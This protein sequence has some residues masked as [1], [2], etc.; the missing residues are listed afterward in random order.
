VRHPSPVDLGRSARRSF[1]ASAVLVVIAL[2]LAP[3][4]GE[5]FGAAFYPTQSVGNR[6]TDVGAIQLLLRHRGLTT[7]FDRNFGAQTVA[8]VKAFQSRAALTVNGIVGPATWAKLVVPLATGATGAAVKA[9]Q[10]ELNQKRSAGL[11]LDGTYGT[12]TRAAVAA[13]QR[14][15][16]LTVTGSMN[17]T[18]WRNLIWH[19]EYPAFWLTEL[20]DYTD[21]TRNGPAANW[22]TSAAVRQVETAAKIVHD[23]GKGAVA[24]GDVSW[25]HGGDIRGHGTHERG[26]DVDIRP[27]RT[28]RR[29]C[30]WGTSWRWSTYDRAGTRTLVKAIRSTAPGHVRLVYFN[31]PVLIRE[32]LTRWYTGHDDHLHI[33]YCEKVH[34]DPLYDC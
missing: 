27:I 28:D 25:E 22:G 30:T 32:G 4:R 29:Q 7:P 1:G 10:W 6:G 20:C 5:A 8:A 33:R 16:G 19:Y 18:T 21:L 31:D 13:F 26:L 15:A 12:A 24:V 9:V 3:A 11:T 17:G 2:L 23:T 14:H 34:P